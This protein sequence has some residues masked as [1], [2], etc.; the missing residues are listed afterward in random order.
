MKRLVIGLS[1]TLTVLCMMLSCSTSDDVVEPEKPGTPEVPERTMAPDTIVIRDTIYVRDTIYQSD[2]MIVRDTVIVGDTSPRILSFILLESHNSASLISNVDCE[3]IGDSLIEGWIPHLASDKHLIPHFTSIGTV[4][5]DGSPITS[6]ATVIDFGEPVVLTVGEGSDSKT[7][8]VLIHA[9]T[10]LPVCWIETEGRQKIESKDQYLK[11]HMTIQK[12]VITRANVPYEYDMEIKG[13]G[14]S[15]WILPKKPYRIRFDKKQSI[16]DMPK[17][18]AWA[19]L[20][21]Y[22]DKTMIRNKVAYNFGEMSHLAWTPH[23]HFVEVWVNGKYNGNYQLIE[24]YNVSNNRV[25]IGDEGFLLEIDAYAS[26]ETDARYFG[27]QALPQPVNIKEPKVNWYDEKY[28]LVRDFVNEAETVLYSGDFKDPETGWQKY[29]DATALVDWYLINEIAKCWDAIRWS[30]T[31]MTWIPGGKIV[32]GPLWDY[33]IAFGNADAS[34]GCD[35]SPQEFQV[36][37]MAWMHRFFEDPYFVQLV[38]ERWKYFYS[39][40]S[41][42]MSEINADA[43]Y[44]KYSAV[45]ND[46]KWQTLYKYTE[47]NRDIWGSYFN[48]VE[49]LKQWLNTRMEWL[50]KEFANM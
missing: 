37:N 35:S 18:K 44:L 14:N 15:T 26:G 11:A 22:M 47:R 32:M 38:K 40:K 45:E 4:K 46:N 30:S 19:L 8:R 13:R 28:T 23:S 48:E 25:D 5:V 6:D 27:T 7:Y 31:F 33:D 10:G 12:D 36:K 29:F 41:A 9:F 50:D 1:I 3:I 34:D 43:N 49:Y 20:A 39:K 24:K 2:T 42:I 17:D 16:L 21:N